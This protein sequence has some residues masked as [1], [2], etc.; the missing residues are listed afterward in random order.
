MVLTHWLSPPRFLDKS[1]PL[2]RRKDEEDG[3]LVALDK[4]K[5]R[6]WSKRSQMKFSM[7]LFYALFFL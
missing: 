7:I 3:A 6:I 5:V 1:V 4:F 2:E